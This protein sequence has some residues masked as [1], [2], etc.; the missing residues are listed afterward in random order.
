MNQNFDDQ[1]HV[2]SFWHHESGTWDTRQPQRLL[3]LAQ[4][5]DIGTIDVLETFFLLDIKHLTCT[6]NTLIFDRRRGLIKTKLTTRQIMTTYVLKLGFAGTHLIRG[7]AGR[8]GLSVHKLPVIHGDAVL[9][10][11][12]TAKR[13]TT[14]WYNQHHLAY[15]EDHGFTTDLVY[16]G[17]IRLQVDIS[18]QVVNRQLKKALQLQAAVRVHHQCRLDPGQS[19]AAINDADQ[20]MIRTYTD[21]VLKHYGILALPGEI[22]WLTRQFFGTL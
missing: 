3:P 14:S 19:S 16:D 5:L 20:Q 9:M 1:H 15:F 18:K 21:Q 22:S 13:G 8:L 11:L 7:L 12:G 2:N 17:D 4:R 10:P 6:E